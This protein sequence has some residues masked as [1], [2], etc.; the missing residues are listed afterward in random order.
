MTTTSTIRQAV[1]LVALGIAL[2]LVARA[3][4]AGKGKVTLTGTAV[5]TNG[6]P[7]AGMEI[8]VK[9]V[10]KTYDDGGV[11]RFWTR[12]DT[13]GVFTIEIDRSHLTNETTEVTLEGGKPNPASSEVLTAPMLKKG[14]D[15]VRLDFDAAGA[16]LDVGPV[17]P[18]PREKKK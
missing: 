6:T 17:F 8:V 13:N 1:A 15:P 12:T 16:K 5:T 2:G 10:L 7:I 3:E 14:G 9:G 11:G 4:D 18:K